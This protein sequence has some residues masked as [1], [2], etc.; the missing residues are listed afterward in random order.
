MGSLSEFLKEW[1]QQQRAE[2]IKIS[3]FKLEEVKNWTDAQKQY[4][5]KLFYHLRGHFHDFLWFMANHAPTKEAKQAILGNISE[6]FGGDKKSHEQLY[7]E[8]AS[9][10]G[11]NL[12]DEVANQT[13]YLPFAKEFNRKHLQWLANTDWDG[14]VIAFAA[15][16]RLDN[17]DYADLLSLAQSIG[18]TSRGLLFF[19]VHKKVQHYEMV[20]EYLNLKDLWEKDPQKVKTG[21]NFIGQHQNQMWKN[22][23][24]AVF[25]HK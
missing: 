17:V 18:I 16:E 3:L 2:H 5:V 13:T 22:L 7:F 11:V 8:F 14:K 21:F 9:A 6:E 15:Y 20:E 12:I 4:F 1:D 10:L 25:N 23:S 19:E 24:E